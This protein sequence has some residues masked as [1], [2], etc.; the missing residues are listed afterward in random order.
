MH[1]E[2]EV[3]PPAEPA[4]GQRDASLTAKAL[5]GVKWTSLGTAV[6]ASLQLVFAAVMAR[7]LTPEDFGLIA[8]AQLVLNFGDYFAK[9]GIGQALIQKLELTAEEV[10]A[11]FTSSLLLGLAVTAVIWAG[12][13][14]AGGVFGTP[15]VVPVLRAMGLALLLGSLGQTAEGLLHRGLRFRET[16]LIQ[17]VSYVLGYFGV[18]L[19]M[20][21]AG[22]GVWSLVGAALAQQLLRSLLWYARVRHSLRLTFAGDAYR[23][24]YSFGSRVSLI[25]FLEY[26]G[27]NLDTFMV[28]RYL[29][30]GALGQYNRG[31]LLVQV[32]MYQLTDAVAQVAFP[33]FSQI[34]QDTDR[35]RRAYLSATGLAAAFLLP[36]CFGMAAASREIVLTVLGERWLPVI[37][38]LPI[39]AINGS[40]L[41]LTHF[42]GIVTEAKAEL[43]KKLALQAGYLVVLVGMLLSVRSDELFVYA[44]VFAIGNVLQHAAY[45]VLMHRILGV[46]ARDYGNVYGRA[47]VAA[48]A[49]G[50][51]IS[52]VRMGLL[53]VGAPLTVVLA[54]EVLVG[55]VVLFALFRYG[56]LQPMIADLVSR[57]DGDD[58]GAVGRGARLLLN[59]RNVLAQ[60]V[61]AQQLDTEPVDDLVEPFEPIGAWY[62]PMRGELDPW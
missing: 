53:A 16:S 30:T 41:V 17:M 56:P 47:F 20:A 46:S 21:V 61:A 15:D 11:G 22:F 26:L 1:E 12:A 19:T 60:R 52:A 36:V 23:A 59:P 51:A 62:P 57:L 39:L 44:L 31:N 55:A 25:S 32:P 3:G 27:L 58:G 49:T 28:G 18:G 34:Q 29:P 7:L 4:E 48:I 8:M 10:R 2:P 54:G 42:A 45:M 50:G 40:F 24:L 5:H 43:G 37:T 13:P 33:S 6:A 14:L 9:M 38:I 35:A